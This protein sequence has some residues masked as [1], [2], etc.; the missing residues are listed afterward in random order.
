MKIDK[1]SCTQ[2]A[3][4]RDRDV[5]FDDGINI[6]YG[7]NESGKSTLVNL[8]SN[9]FFH[10]TK[11]I[12]GEKTKFNESYLPSETK[13]NAV[14]G[15]FADGKVTFTTDSGTYTLTKEWG[16]DS[17][18]ML[19]T[20]QGAVRDVKKIEDILKREMM[21]GKGVYS[22]MLFSSQVKTNDALQNILDVSK[23]A[24]VKKELTEVVSK[25][26]SQSDG[27]TAESIEEAID[28]IIKELE[29]KHWD[30]VRHAPEKSGKRWQREI[31]EVMKAYYAWEDAEDVLRQV[32]QRENEADSAS[33]YYAF[34]EAALLKAEEAH[35]KFNS[36][37]G[38]LREKQAAQVHIKDCNE[39]L[40]RMKNALL[41]IPVILEGIEKATALQNEKTQRELLDR[42]DL[43]KKL[44]DG[45][46]DYEKELA[47]TP[48]PDD[49]EIKDAKAAR[50]KIET[51]ENKLCGMNISAAVNMLGGHTAKVT[52]L[53]TGEELDLTSGNTALTEA[54]KITIPE[55]MEL[56]LSPADV[57]VRYITEQ[58]ADSRAV[59]DAVFDKYGVNTVEQLESLAQKADRIKSSYELKKAEFNSLMKMQS[60]EELAAEAE[61][62]NGEVRSMEQINNDILTVC[63][64]SDV[65]RFITSNEAKAESF[66]SEYTGIDELQAKVKDAE[67]DIIETNAKI[68]A[69]G[70]I[71]R[72][73][74]N[75]D[76]P[77]AYLEKLKKDVKARREQKENALSAKSSALGVLEAYKDSLDFDP[78]EK[79]ASTKKKF[80][81]KDSLLCHWKNIKKVFEAQKSGVNDNPFSDIA[82]SFT[83][84][85]GMISGG[86]V[87]SELKQS[88]KLDM[89]IYSHDRR[90]DYSKL[91]EGTKETVSLAFR[92][93]VLDHLFP[94]GGGVIVFD[95]PLA[96]MDSERAAQSCRLI[97]ECAKVHQ[98]IFL[99]CRDDYKNLLGGKVIALD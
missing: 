7:K 78:I 74:A 34:S 38:A 21:Y 10:S 46:K 52:V 67:A 87:E 40:A 62:I 17:R 33:K 41:Q 55:V 85:L 27:V 57:D 13:A 44:Y 70:D 24:D 32:E 5:S 71:P 63:R 8:I 11:A 15:D 72:E 30:S 3:G 37:V 14:K 77:E 48:R 4:I 79:A 51:L 65:S 20:P 50:R 39:K 28:K 9:T 84:Y 64:T 66:K 98:V 89:N 25:A 96:N 45:L 26:F 75:I 73:F 88:G 99:T 93:A 61:A 56:Q 36:C 82:E 16:S 53:R 31:G 91:S 19:S 43:A 76:D 2:F 97:E 47:A 90:I 81:E 68:A 42:Y 94:N 12:R 18:C 54:V 83:K 22:E 59:I 49:R 86:N 58:I 92:L 29:G 6:I 95:D 69:A 60:Y 23:A 1:V 80:E 35:E